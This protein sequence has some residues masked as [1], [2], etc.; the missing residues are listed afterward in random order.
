MTNTKIN[1]CAT[2]KQQSSWKLTWLHLRL[3]LLFLW[4]FNAHAATQCQ[5]SL[6]VV[7][8]FERCFVSAVSVIV[9]GASRAGGE[10]QRWKMH[11][12]TINW[13][14]YKQNMWVT[15]AIQRRATTLQ[16]RMQK[17]ADKYHI[18]QGRMIVGKFQFLPWQ[19]KNW[20][21]SWLLKEKHQRS[22]NMW[23]YIWKKNIESHVFPWF[24]QDL[25]M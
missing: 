13:R 19:K 9:S 14:H 1:C 18:I 17:R 12:I 2:N 23:S 4:F 6:S 10:Q 22:C 8:R 7:R 11:R 25:G 16:M 21:N 20:V 24:G 15:S 5:L 3:L